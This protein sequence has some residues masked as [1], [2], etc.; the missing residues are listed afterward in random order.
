MTALVGGANLTFPFSARSPV[1]SFSSR[2]LRAPLRR[3]NA[4]T[5]G[6]IL[7]KIVFDAPQIETA[8]QNRGCPESGTKAQSDFGAAFD[9]RRRGAEFSPRDAR[10]FHVDHARSGELSPNQLGPSPRGDRRSRNAR[11]CPPAPPRPIDDHA[12]WRIHLPISAAALHARTNRA[13][14]FRALP[15]Y[16]GNQ[17]R[18]RRAVSNHPSGRLW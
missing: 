6:A 17:S 18:F 8:N 12:C 13:S 4:W 14:A 7:L 16:R 9:S 2:T 10:S 5:C 15:P 11:L 3:R 1:R